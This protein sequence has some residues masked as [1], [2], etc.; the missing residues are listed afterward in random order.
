MTARV[1]HAPL[2]VLGPDQCPDVTTA[3]WD[4]ETCPLPEEGYSSVQKVRL[5]KLSDA[6]MRRN[7]DSDPEEVDRRVRSVTA[8][9]G[10]ICCLSVHVRTHTGQS[11]TFSYSASSPDE[12]SSLIQQFWMYAER[13]PIH[14]WL[15]F[16]GK[17][18]DVRFLLQ[19]S[20]HHGIPPLN[21]DVIQ[22]HKYRHTPH[23]DLSYFYDR[24]GLADVCEL[25]GVETPKEGSVTASTVWKAVEEGRID[26]VVEYCE[27]D[28]VATMEC[29]LK[30]PFIS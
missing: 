28:V 9:L 11:H 25:L 21:R 24:L 10:W 3:A 20:A 23:C 1:G 27:R 18:F 13:A 8:T 29:Y 15:T 22:D 30:T 12:E 7:P 2:V 17:F 16:N 5:E 19:R 4:I 14:T 26:E 6:E